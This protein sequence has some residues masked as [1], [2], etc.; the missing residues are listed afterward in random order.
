MATARALPARGISRAAASPQRSPPVR[1]GAPLSGVTQLGPSIQA[2]LR[3]GPVDDPLEHEADRVADA[4]TAGHFATPSAD[5]ALPAVRRACNEC[6]AEEGQTLRRQEAARGPEEEEEEIQTLRRQEDEREPEEEEQTLRRQAGDRMP[7]EDEEEPVRLKPNGSGAPS[8]SLQTAA[9][10]VTGGGAPLPAMLRRYFEPR[11]GRDLGNVRIHTDASA[12]VA[13]ASIN[14]RAYALG[15]HIAFAPREYDDTSARGRH[16]LA[17]ELA[18]TLQRNG[19]A[20][21]TLRRKESC[22]G[23]SRAAGGAA[24]RQIQSAYPSLFPGVEP[25]IPHARKPRALPYPSTCKG[26]GR[27]GKVDLWRQDGLDI[28][29]GEIKSDWPG[30]VAR[31]RQEVEYYLQFA[32][33]SVSRL[34][35]TGP[36]RDQKMTKQDET[37]DDTWLGGIRFSFFEPHFS[38]LTAQPVPVIATPLGPFERDPR[39]TLWHRHAGDG[40]VAY[41]CETDR[42]RRRRGS[43]KRQ[44]EAPPIA[45]REPAAR[46][47]ARRRPAARFVEPPSRG[48]EVFFPR[49]GRPPMITDLPTTSEPIEVIFAVPEPFYVVFNSYTE[50]LS[51]AAEGPPAL[52]RTTVWDYNVLQAQLLAL[53]V[54]GVSLAALFALGAGAAASGLSAAETGAIYEAAVPIVSGGGAEVIPIGTAVA[55]APE[56]VAAAAIILIALQ[57]GEAKAATIERVSRALENPAIFNAVLA[58]EIGEDQRRELGDSIVLDDGKTY[59]IIGS[60]E[61]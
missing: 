44:A 48:Y 12:G 40:V 42:R 16:L 27:P 50:T 41:W 8:A 21:R 17:H 35:R 19:A 1:S 49:N 37:F 33:Y 13:A 28:E 22:S 46:S 51:G 5:H 29:I 58:D 32:D 53:G 18:H 23:S 11:F 52:S 34:R 30:A 20:H 36:C 61:Y 31:G 4:V 39:Q 10:V 57:S 24:H 59:M 7:D 26:L 3:I 14:A 45:P 15:D 55:A 56:G 38:K 9:S 25:L 54:A 60:A 2:K 43:E 6:A 47:V